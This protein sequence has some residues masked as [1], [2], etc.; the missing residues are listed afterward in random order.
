M[1]CPAISR[2]GV[3]SVYVPPVGMRVYIVEMEGV[4]YVLVY[5]PVWLTASGVSIYVCLATCFQSRLSLFGLYKRLSIPIVSSQV[6]LYLHVLFCRTYLR[7][8]QYHRHRR[9]AGYLISMPYPLSTSENQG[10]SPLQKIKINN[11]P[12]TPYRRFRCSRRGNKRPTSVV[13]AV[14]AG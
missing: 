13:S 9:Y 6:V 5:L 11:S 10:S 14:K 4:Y 8:I 1:T 12:S 3:I 7:C 2:V